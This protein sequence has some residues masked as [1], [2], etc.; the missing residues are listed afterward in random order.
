MDSK[1]KGPDEQ[2][3]EIYRDFIRRKHP[4]HL[5][6]WPILSGYN[7]KIGQYNDWLIIIFEHSGNP[8]FKTINGIGHLPQNLIGSEIIEKNN[9]EKVRKRIER[10]YNIKHMDAVVLIPPNGDVNYEL[11]KILQKHEYAMGLTPMKIFLSHKG[12][13]KGIVREYKKILEELGFDPWLDEDAMSA[14]TELERGILKGFN[15]SCAAIFFITPNFKD[16]NYLATEVDYAIAEKRNKGDKFSIITL[17]FEKDGQKG[18]VPNL[19]HRYVWKE[20][21]NDLEALKE[22]LRALPV[23]VG[24]I[25]WKN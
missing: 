22:I 20:P 18:T 14:G 6:V 24:D 5:S 15:D 17:V 19:L 8:G 13:D 11:N 25:Y 3:V 23:K 7:A 21:K 10:H 2:F 1:Q 4:S 16:E 12:A 9:I